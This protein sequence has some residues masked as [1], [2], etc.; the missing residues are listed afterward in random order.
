VASKGRD[1]LQKSYKTGVR[2]G[3]F[4][5]YLG[6]LNDGRI[7]A[8]NL[9]ELPCWHFTW[10]PDSKHF[11]FRGVTPGSIS[12]I[13]GPPISI[14][15]TFMDWIDATHYSYMTGNSPDTFKRYIG[16]I[17]GEPILAPTPTANK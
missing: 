15:G 16:E 17:G 6:N 1:S 10:S 7:Q 3:P 11:A 13:D 12:S 8:Y 5:G 9:P 2:E 14:D 4:S